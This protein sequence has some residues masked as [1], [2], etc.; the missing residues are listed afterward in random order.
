MS[1]VTVI[2]LTHFMVTVMDKLMLI[3][4]TMVM[5]KSIVTVI[6]VVLKHDKY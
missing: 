2:I 4:N 3:V 5:I 6:V 1:M